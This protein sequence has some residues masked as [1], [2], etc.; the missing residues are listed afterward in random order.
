MRLISIPEDKYDE[1]RLSVIF[2]CYKWDPQFLDNNTI[3]KYVLV[4]TKEEHEELQRLTEK[5]DEETRNA[6]VFLNNNFKYTKPLA[7]PKGIC[8]HC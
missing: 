4:I 5:L 2:D 8:K 7:L 1:Y 6:E 3:A